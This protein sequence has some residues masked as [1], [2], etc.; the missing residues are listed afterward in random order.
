[1][2]RQW[3]HAKRLVAGAKKAKTNNKLVRDIAL[4]ARGGADPTMNARLFVAVEKAKKESVPKDAIQRAIN[5]GA[6]VGDDK[7]VLEHV[8]YEGRAPHNVPVIVEVY[9][10]N[11]QRTAPE[12]RVLFRKGRLDSSGANKFIFDQVGLVE[13]H[14]PDAKVD[15]EEAAIEAGA[16]EVSPLTHEQND[17]VPRD[18]HGARFVCDRT[19]VAN[20]SKWLSSHG[21]TVVT[22]EIGYQPKTF[23]ELTEEQL[24]EVGEFLHALDEHDDVHRVYAALK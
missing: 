7:L 20:V 1:M 16:N 3:L 10:D 19:E 12:M 13:A 15:P 18:A 6:G 24:V 21:W 14:T 23:S 17:D 8:V 5:K 4:A 22:S 11:L 9:T 2:G